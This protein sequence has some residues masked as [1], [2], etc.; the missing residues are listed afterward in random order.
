MGTTQ[1]PAAQ[2]EIDLGYR[3][4]DLQHRAQ[5]SRQAVCE[6]TERLDWP[7][8]SHIRVLKTYA[9]DLVHDESR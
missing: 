5:I 8:T 2:A 6:R 9:R 7:S 3:I 4:I 1:K